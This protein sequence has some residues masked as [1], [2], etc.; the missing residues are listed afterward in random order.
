MVA[1]DV[2]ENEYNMYIWVDDDPIIGDSDH[3][4]HFVMDHW[5][6]QPFNIISMLL[7]TGVFTH[8]PMCFPSFDA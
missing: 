2:Y 4:D 3:M 7:D 5:E 1:L 8:F 6:I